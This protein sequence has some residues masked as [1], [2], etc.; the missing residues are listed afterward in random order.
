MRP[1]TLRTMRL[2]ASTLYATTRFC[3]TCTPAAPVA[4]TGKV[5]WPD[6]GTWRPPLATRRP[7][8]AAAASCGLPVATSANSAICTTRAP[9]HTRRFPTGSA[10][11]LRL[12][13][14]VS[15]RGA[16]RLPQ[17][18]APVSLPLGGLL[19]LPDGLVC[20]RRPVPAVPAGLALPARHPIGVK[21]NPG[22]R[23]LRQ[24]QLPRPALVA[25]DPNP[26]AVPAVLVVLVVLVL[27]PAHVAVQVEDVQHV[28]DALLHLRLREGGE[29]QAEREPVELV[30]LVVRE[31]THMHRLADGHVGQQRRDG[32]RP[33]RLRLTCRLL[34]GVQLGLQVQLDLH[35]THLRDGLV[36]LPEKPLLQLEAVD[37]GL[38]PP[39]RVVGRRHGRRHDLGRHDLGRRHKLGHR[40]RR[41]RGHL[42]GGGDWSSGGPEQLNDVLVHVP[43]QLG[44]DGAQRLAQ[45]THVAAGVGDK[46]SV[47]NTEGQCSGSC[48]SRH[49]QSCLVG[50]A[51]RGSVFTCS[52]HI[53]LRARHLLAKVVQRLDVRVGRAGSRPDPSPCRTRHQP[54]QIAPAEDPDDR[55][56]AQARVVGVAVGRVRVHEGHVLGM[57]AD[58]LL[59]VKRVGDVRHVHERLLL[60]LAPGEVHRHR[61]V[62]AQVPNL[63]DAVDVQRGRDLVVQVG[64]H[65]VAP[66]A[67]RLGVQDLQLRRRHRCPGVHAAL[68]DHHRRAVRLL[69]A[70]HAADGQA[71]G[72]AGRHVLEQLAVVDVL[73]RGGLCWNSWPSL[74]FLGVADFL[75]G[76]A[77]SAAGIGG[78]GAESGKFYSISTTTTTVEWT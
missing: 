64:H 34:Q 59:H 78:L 47:V 77:D 10:D 62:A 39:G 53:V 31:G 11:A 56:E 67:V 50:P 9:P 46:P 40:R 42:V 44:G 26:V 73:G 75:A 70:E 20:G 72:R 3:G 52:G 45:L 54:G 5:G 28:A 25:K 22:N 7:G 57:V 4:Q 15:P 38:H 74:T 19:G 43:A 18:L 23:R 13:R 29:V 14:P 6:A 1:R 71:V 24:H 63:L 60:Q 2:T 41:A 58:P 51:V 32:R 36:A 16:Q 27:E 65:E 69:A 37:L 35:G 17:H 48:T 8:P 21:V 61:P 49:I 30:H 66:V 76:L 33:L 68:P 12:D 55:G